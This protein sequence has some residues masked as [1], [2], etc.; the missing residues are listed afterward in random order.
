[1]T[2]IIELK[3]I[4]KSYSTNNERIN[5]LND[6]NVYF[7]DGKLYAIKGHSGS[8][9]S[10]LVNIIGLIDQMDEGQYILNGKLI[11]EFSDLNL[12]KLR[13]TSIGFIHQD[14]YLIPEMKAYENVMLPL[15][16]TKGENKKEKACNLLK[17]VGL[18]NR[19]NH[20]P[21]ELSG[22][23]QQRVAIARALINEP[24]IILAD[25]PTGNLDEKNEHQIFQLLKDI[26][27]NGRCVIVVS[28]SNEIDKYAD[29]I[30]IL[31]NGTIGKNNEK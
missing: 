22:G 10:T 17:K 19:L 21:R 4:S 3:N 2:K 27:K 28:H 6:I 20:F 1:M 30:L 31:K 15:I 8:G 26:S 23:E 11:N 9:K 14:F 24:K 12:S 7:E 16:L 25:E 13:M 29:K 18:E 5:V